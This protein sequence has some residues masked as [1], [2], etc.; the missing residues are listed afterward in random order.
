M[1]DEPTSDPRGADDPAGSGSAA[2]ADGET[3]AP[4]PDPAPAPTVP[5]ANGETVPTAPAV[6]KRNFFRRHL[7]LTSLLVI[8]LLLAGSASGFLWYLN[9]ELGQ[10]RQIAN[11]GI[12]PRIDPDTGEPIPDSGNPLNIL[13]LGSDDGDNVPTVADDLAD[14]T[15]TK[16]VH[17][18][19]TIILVHVP[20]D[21]KSVQ[22]ISIP[23]DAWVRVP[24]FPGDVRGKAKINAAFSWGGPA[25]AVRTIQKFTDLHIDHL[26]MIDWNG[27]KGLTDALGGV[28]VYVPETFTDDSQHV[29]WHKGWQTLNGETAL[30]YVRT[31]H[32]LANG[33]FGLIQRQQ[34]FLRT[35]LDSVLSTGTL[36]NPIK[37]ARVVGTIS[38]FVQVDDTWSTGE[39]R[40]LAW[41]SRDLRAGNVQ[42]TTAPLGSY[43]RVDGQSIVRL[44]TSKCKKLFRAFDHGD[45]T[46]YLKDHPGSSLPGNQAIK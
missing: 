5:T 40:D 37:L 15:W 22:V 9:H 28:R 38:S 18:S 43:D 42:F 36:L 25:L 19:D 10:I 21:R 34:N 17:R 33:D 3:A 27:F 24:T 14:G 12:T 45:L 35:I 44:D 11:S 32:G 41:S 29:T 39:I 13:I 7:A 6:K 16:G 20:A 46:E 26:A 31:R 8:L 2:P 1:S 23:R 30:Q 4:A